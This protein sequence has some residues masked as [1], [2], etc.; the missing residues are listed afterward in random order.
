MGNAQPEVK[1]AADYIAGT[2]DED[3]LVQVID[4]FIWEKNQG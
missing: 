3:G 1:A 4:K 2:N